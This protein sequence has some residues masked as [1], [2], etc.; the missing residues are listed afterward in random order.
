MISYIST[1]FGELVKLAIAVNVAAQ[2]FVALTPT[3]RDNEI[4]NKYYKKIEYLAGMFGYAKQPG[5]QKKWW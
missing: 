1:N 3:P 4:Y 2:I 5:G